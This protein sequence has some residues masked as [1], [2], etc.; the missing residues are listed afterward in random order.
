MAM[1]AAA[2]AIC[3]QR[4]IRRVSVPVRWSFGRNDFTSAAHSRP[5]FVT[6]KASTW[7]M[8]LWPEA[9]ASKND[10]LPSPIELTTPTPV[11][12]TRTS[13]L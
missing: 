3:E 9:S 4:P 13:D 6:S 11:M 10:A 2:I 5:R 12:N 7:E 8:P 1:R